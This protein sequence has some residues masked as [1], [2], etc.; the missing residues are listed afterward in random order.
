MKHVKDNDLTQTF[1]L[2]NLPEEFIP[3]YP[4]SGVLCQSGVFIPCQVL[5]PD[6]SSTRHANPFR[7]TQATKIVFGVI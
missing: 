3:C 1:R 7:V 5:S 2:C 6:I 4:M